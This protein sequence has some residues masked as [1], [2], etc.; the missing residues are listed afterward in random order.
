MDPADPAEV[1][2]DEEAPEAAAAVLAPLEPVIVALTV[3]VLPVEAPVETAA[4]LFMVL[5]MADPL[6]EPVP[7]A[8][9]A[10]LIEL[11]T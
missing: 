2:E 1:P 11:T 8:P 10:L 7:M 3:P 4:V 6:E 5:M 9:T